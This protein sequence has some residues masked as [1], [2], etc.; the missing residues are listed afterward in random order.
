M[1]GNHPTSPEALAASLG[2]LVR[3]PSVN[4]LHAGPDSGHAG[5]RRMADWLADRADSLG[6]EVVVD[7]VADGRCNV[8]ATVA[9]SSERTLAIDVHLDT[10]GVEHMA[11]DPFD[12]AVEGS[13]VFGRGAVDTKASL[14][15]VL[16]VLRELRS[17]GRRPVPTVQVVGTVGE[18][19]GGFPGAMR[20][21]D[22]LSQNGVPVDQLIVA[23]ELD[24]LL[25]RH[26]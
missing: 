3:I 16:E 22:W 4:P 11:R 12:G 25:Q 17:E 14:A 26:T 20:Y 19:A 24:R 6:A 15:V 10:V 13:R 8:Y 2:E 23:D 5:E 18:E 1:G 21:R 9:G 7:H